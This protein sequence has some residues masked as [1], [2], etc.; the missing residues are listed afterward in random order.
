MSIEESAFQGCSGL[1]EINIPEG[2]TKISKKAFQ[3]CGRLRR[4][5]L[6]KSLES[7][8]TETFAGVDATI[9]YPESSHDESWVGKNYGGN[10]TW[11]AM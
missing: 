7:I 1:E 10:L 2:V 8:G 3:F 5:T 9:Y 11:V 6:P 4:I